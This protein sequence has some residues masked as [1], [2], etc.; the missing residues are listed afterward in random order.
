MT[1]PNSIQQ[2]GGQAKEASPGNA[3]AK[4]P[5][6]QP[7]RPRKV[8]VRSPIVGERHVGRFELLYRRPP[9][10]ARIAWVFVTSSGRCI[11]YPPNLPPTTG[12]LLWSGART[13]YEV[14]LGVH[15][16][17][18]E[19]APPSHGDKIAF[20]ANIDLVWQVINPSKVVRAGIKDV[21]QAVS[22]FL[23]SRLRAVT[24]QYE[25]DASEKAEQAAN[26]EFQDGTLGADF[27]LSLQ[28]FVRLSMDESSLTYAAIQRK[29]EIYRDIIAQGDYNQF[30]LQL[31]ANPDDVDTVVRL[32]VNERDSHRQ[33]V[34]DFV[35]RLLESDALDRWQID[36]QVR[37]TL[38]WLRD[39]GYKVLT[40]T[41]QARVT[42]FGDNHRGPKAGGRA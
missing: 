34:F 35:T 7:A 30:A 13:M 36:D 20:H 18:I 32:L 33:A 38:Q 19:A 14:D 40:G 17:Q 29:V 22:P 39:S 12:E 23:L 25:I 15:V 3:P 27:G 24:R 4:A 26:D 6:K 37:T 5:V 11:G 2:S 31:A 16:T 9:T 8:E 21:G 42:S 10:S 28:V 1:R 41:D